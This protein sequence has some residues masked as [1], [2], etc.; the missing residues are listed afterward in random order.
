MTVF[1][2]FFES[3]VF[4]TMQALASILVAFTLLGL[5]PLEHWWI[6][7][8]D[9]PRL[10]I[11]FVD[12]VCF[13]GLLLFLSLDFYSF[14][15]A[16]QT[17]LLILLS[18]LFGV[19]LYQ[20]YMVL[21]YT[22]LWR[23]QVVQTS[24]DDVVAKN[25]HNVQIKLMVAN[26]LTSNNKTAALIE[27]INK[28]T[29]DVLLTLETD[30]KWQDALSTINADY[31]YCVKVP[32]D[33]L[34]GM[35]LYSKFELINPQVKYMLVDDVP[36]IHTQLKLPN[37]KQVWL[38]C[39]HPMP[40]APM[41]ADK[42]TTRDAEILMIAKKI[43]EQNQT[44]IV[45][46]DL[47]DVAWSRTTKRFQRISGLLDPRIGRTFINTFHAKLPFLRWA[48]DHVF[49]SACFGLVDIK[50]LPDIGSD[51]FP[52]LTVLY[53]DPKVVAYQQNNVPLATKSDVRQAEQCIARGRL[54]GIKL[55]QKA[56]REWNK[57]QAVNNHVY[58]R[59]TSKNS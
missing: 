21:P 38:Y 23:V 40:P 45:A 10:Q 52:L 32:L 1:I 39:L 11:I 51:H 25:I 33:N 55:S 37:G 53:Y 17:F 2:L 48:L 44:A 43:R 34:Y 56:L 22:R 27:Q 6:R 47:N 4:Y 12:M 57:P 24:L 46:G 16:Q 59:V 8:A 20:L 49:H 28:H 5:L 18:L 31:P 35:H 36:S 26:V 30:K 19:L 3:F 41:E 7:L 29:P 13:V 14:S 42:S 9:F 54:E 15:T 50:R 58:A